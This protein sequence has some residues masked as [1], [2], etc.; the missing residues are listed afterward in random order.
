MNEELKTFLV[1][2]QGIMA[3]MAWM[4]GIVIILE[5][6]PLK[7]MLIFLYI[8][9]SIGVVEVI[10]RRIKHKRTRND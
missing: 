5:G 2:T 9:A 6:F 1:A 4:A 3:A 10:K 7:G 8:A